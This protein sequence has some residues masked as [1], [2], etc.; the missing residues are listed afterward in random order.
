MY[1]KFTNTASEKHF[2]FMSGS[3]TWSV[4]FINIHPLSNYAEQH[5]ETASNFARI[6]KSKAEK[7]LNS[8]VENSITGKSRYSPS[9]NRQQ[10][11][12]DKVS[13]SQS[14]RD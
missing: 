3:N 2:V 10:C 6:L 9:E 11:S 4:L 13:K 8:S 12:A 5:I 1:V 7:N 14:Q